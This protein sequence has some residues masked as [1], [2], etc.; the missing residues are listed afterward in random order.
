MSKYRNINESDIERL[1]RII[2]ETD[3]ETKE[4]DEILSGTKVGDFL[5]GVKGL[6]KG[7][8]FGYFKYLSKIK[9]RSQKVIKELDDIEKFMEE[10]KELKPRVD[11]LSIAPEKK[12]RLINLLDF[13]ITKW[14]PFFPGYK[15]ALAEINVLSSEKLG[16]QRLDVIPGSKKSALGAKYFEDKDAV[17]G[18][19][20]TNTIT[21]TDEPTTT[22]TTKKPSGFSSGSISKKPELTKADDP[23]LEEVS[24]FKQLIK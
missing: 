9:N 1:S 13:V 20:N 2:V 7:E 8:G 4:L 24:R 16:G 19:D 5:Q 6:Y 23:L 12:M 3:S 22:T 10:L 15:K 14:E 21:K 11:K 18:D 17:D